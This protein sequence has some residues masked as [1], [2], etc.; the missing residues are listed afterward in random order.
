MGKIELNRSS[1][2]DSKYIKKIEYNNNI[3]IQFRQVQ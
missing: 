2:E 3:A 1:E